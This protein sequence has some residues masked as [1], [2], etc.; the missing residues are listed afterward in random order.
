LDTSF[1]LKHTQSYIYLSDTRSLFCGITH[2]FVN[3]ELVLVLQKFIVSSC[4]NIF[5]IKYII[6]L[7]K[8]MLNQSLY[9]TI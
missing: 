9:Y 2:T 1:I 4:N 7:K 6:L 8:T 5:Y 3:Y